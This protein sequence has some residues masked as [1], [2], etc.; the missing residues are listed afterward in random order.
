MI[1]LKEVTRFQSV[2]DCILVV[3]FMVDAAGGVGPYPVLLIVGEAGSAKTT[4]ARMIGALIDPRAHFM[5]TEPSNKRDV[6]INA[7][8]RAILAYNNLSNLPKPISDALCTTGEGGTDSQRTLYTNDEESAIRAK[9]PTIL[10]AIDNIVRLGD[11]SDRTMKVELASIPASERL[12]ETDVWARFDEAAPVILRALLNALSVGLRRYDDIDASNLPRMAEFSRFV[13]ACETAFWDEGSFAAAFAES[14][15]SASD[16]VLS[17]DPVAKT[18][19][20]FMADKAEWEGTATDLLLEL[21]TIVRRPEREAELALAAL[22]NEEKNLSGRGYANLQTDGEKENRK[23]L[24]RRIAEAAVDL[25]EARERVHATLDNKWPR[26]ANV[27]SMRLKSVGPQ[28]RGAG[29]SIYWP[30]SHRAGRVLRAKNFLLKAEADPGR[31]SP[32]SPPATDSENV[33]DNND[34]DK[35]IHPISEA[36]KAARRNSHLEEDRPHRERI[37]PDPDYMPPE[38]RIR[39]GQNKSSSSVSSIRPSGT[40]SPGLHDDDEGFEI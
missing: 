6:F 34:I 11:L 21:E 40:H 2:R 10:V 32:A 18:F 14:A 39:A 7:A 3:G 24:S 23:E 15:A 9:V 38:E 1:K 25:K 36:R 30:T 20:E 29:V 19:M 27:L 22:K 26:G 13:T 17:G 16:D 4:L 37:V 12:S 5:L 31:S 28:L 8:N 33:R 35:N